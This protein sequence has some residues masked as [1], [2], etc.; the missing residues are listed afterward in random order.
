MSDGNAVANTH[1][2]TPVPHEA[3]ELEEAEELVAG[4][5]AEPDDTEWNVY[6]DSYNLDNNVTSPYSNGWC[7]QIDYNP[8]TWYVPDNYTRIQWAINN[9]TAGD[10]IIVRDGTYNEN[11]NMN[12][13]LTIQS[14][15][16]SA[17]CIVQAANSSN[18]VFEVTADHVNIHGF[19]VRD[20]T[21]HWNAGIYLSNVN[22]CTISD[23]NVS[24]T[25]WGIHLYCSSSNIIINNRFGND[26]IFIRGDDLS[27]YNTHVIED[28]KLNGK[29][30]YYYKNANAIK[31]PE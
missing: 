1:H 15:N 20:A 5:F 29:P 9:A 17:N 10:I 8:A 12:K 19:T 25:T 14:E 28:N 3:N 26:G 16:G 2:D 11:V 4:Y 30:I 23:N 27:Y 18:H 6:E 13:R 31:V 21:E 24:N 22:H 7:T